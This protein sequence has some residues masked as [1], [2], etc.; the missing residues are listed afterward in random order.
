MYGNFS[1]L[2]TT[3]EHKFMN[4]NCLFRIQTNIWFLGFMFALEKYFPHFGT[5]VLLFIVCI[6]NI[7]MGG[8]FKSTQCNGN[9]S[10]CHFNVV[11]KTQTEFTELCRR[12]NYFYADKYA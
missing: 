4:F 2:W 11:C 6:I 7:A 1:V 9:E 3:Y 8:H 5:T 12:H 10:A